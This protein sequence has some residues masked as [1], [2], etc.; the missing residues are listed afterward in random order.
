MKK[1]LSSAQ[2]KKKING[3]NQVEI[4]YYVNKIIRQI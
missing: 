2:K 4:F 3:K 1:V